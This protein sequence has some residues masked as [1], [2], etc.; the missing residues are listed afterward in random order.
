MKKKLLEKN[1]KEL[2]ESKN[3]II[4]DPNIKFNNIYYIVKEKNLEEGKKNTVC[5]ECKEN[6]HVDCLDTTVFGVDILK[7]WCICFDKIG[8]CKVC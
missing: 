6:C 4:K 1:K 8:F 2:S 3:K 7:Y 5:K